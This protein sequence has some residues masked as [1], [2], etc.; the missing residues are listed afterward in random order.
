MSSLAPPRRAVLA[1]CVGA[2]APKVHAQAARPLLKGVNI[3]GLEFNAGRLPGRVDT[4]YV[5]PDPA[6]LAY[7][8]DA[9]AGLV[10][11]PFLWERLQPDLDGG[12]DERYFSLITGAIGAA[13]GMRVVLD[14]HQYGRRRVE[15]RELVIGEAREVPAQSFAEFWAALAARVRHQ[16]RVM[17]GLQN[18]P[19]DQDM[20]VLV[21][22]QNEAIAAIRRTGAQQTIL[23][24]GND[25]SGA[26]SWTSGRNG[27]AMLAI[28]DP[29]GNFHFDAHQYLDPR[30]SGTEAHCTPGSG[31]RL[32][33]LT[34]WAR[35]NGRTLFLGEFG[36]GPGAACADELTAM[37]QHTERNADVWRGWAYWAG[38]AWW[39]DSYPFVVRPAR[40]GSGDERPQMR[41]LRRF[42]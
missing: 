37:L 22:V 14:A 39:P 9:G 40:L 16:P 15:G 18:E 34:R 23:V 24:C 36:G 20:D 35:A 2:C 10:R 25:W 38:G 30:S 42:F 1:A 5:A 41:I 32:E 26:H 33:R 21:R 4:D 11:I 28:R 6:E 12:F 27:A 3:A 17:F 31:G 7:Y 19:H 8:R 13:E 29:A